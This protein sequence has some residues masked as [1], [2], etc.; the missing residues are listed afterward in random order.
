MSNLF[1]EL[2]IEVVKLSL[3]P[4]AG[5]SAVD[6][7]FAEDYWPAGT[8]YSTNPACYPLLAGSPVVR[9]GVEVYN[10]IKHDVSISLYA[11]SHLSEFGKTLLDLFD[12]YEIHNAYADVR[13]Y[14]KPVAESVG[15]SS[16]SALS[17]TPLW[18]GVYFA[19]PTP[20]GSIDAG[21][22][23]HLAFTYRGLWD[24]GGTPGPALTTHDDTV[25]IRQT[26]RVV[27]TV[28]D[29]NAGILTLR[30][31]DVWFKN[32]EVSRKAD[33]TT[34]TGLD[35]KWVGEYLA[36]VFGQSTVAGDGIAIDAP[37]FASGI[38]GS[39]RP[40][41]K[42]FS[43]WTFPNH[44]N[45]AFKRLMVR[46]QFKAQD[47]SEWLQVNLVSDPQT[48]V[49]GE[50]LLGGGTFANLAEYTRAILYS[51]ATYAEILSVVR[52]FSGTFGTI[53]TDTGVLKTSVH[54]A[55]Y[56]PTSDTYAP[57]GSPLRS[58]SKDPKA[59]TVAAGTDQCDFMFDQP[60]V[61]SAQGN[62]FI[63]QEWSNTSDVVNYAAGKYL[64]TA[65][66]THYARD[67]SEKDRGWAKQTDIRYAYELFVIGD[68]DDAFEDGTAS[69]T[70][71]YS[72]YHLEGKSAA[73]DTGQT[74]KGL[75]NG[76]E[77]KICVSGL[78]DDG[79]GT[80]TG[81]ANAVIEKPGHI[82]KFVLM[83]ED[84]GLGL[85]SDDVYT[86]TIATAVS[87]ID[88]AY[89]N[90]LQMQIVINKETDAEGLILEIC[91]QARMIFYKTR[92]GKL[93]LHAPVVHT[94]VNAE[95]S[96]ARDRA[97]LDLVSVADNAYGQV[98]NEFHQFYQL[99]PINQPNDAAFL[100][101]NPNEKLANELYITPD[102]STSGDGYHSALCS[103]SQTLYGR[104]E[105]AD[106]LTFY[107][108]PTYAQPVQNYYCARYAKLQ[109]RAKVRVPR[110][111]W[112]E[113]LD[114]FSAIRVVHTGIPDALGTTL[115]GKAHDTGT[116]YPAYDEGVPTLI[117]AGGTLEGQVVEVEESGQ[118][119]SLT[120][121]T[122][123]NFI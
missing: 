16:D 99:D 93:A 19:L 83:N 23:A 47:A 67:N 2:D 94:T 24:S 43:G 37:F 82:I 64:A 33:S 69:G 77:F 72:Y 89:T 116:P 36:T 66:H 92:D 20:D 52:F 78:A 59:A 1:P 114:V 15:G 101:R 11:D 17:S 103:A 31:R 91:R 61:L 30:C 41:V 53:A 115:K 9:R 107:D 87:T 55:Q 13:Y 113:S 111:D 86:S 4:K 7:Y 105:H 108:S 14:A 45:K 58:E 54:D 5:G 117:W 50:S 46:N 112:F 120:I 121:E 118:W 65:G 8:I 119:M 44:P 95:F 48:Q 6:Y 68:G 79:S 84:F 22:L 21:D 62:Y 90:G 56:Q 73:I 38:D 76:L 18:G 70:V 42:V 98:I 81:S 35:S 10:G 63:S 29:A 27:D 122:I 100:R 110:R 109:R 75:T 26:L 80:Y 34:L 40:N 28:Y 3:L 96:E 106:P 74:R 88:A 57:I 85:T 51:P 123:S 102:G 25:N 97:D 32:K 71:R 12:E 49:D 104:R 60:V 39:N